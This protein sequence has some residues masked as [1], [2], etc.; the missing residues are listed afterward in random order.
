MK[1][2]KITWDYQYLKKQG[3]EYYNKKKYKEA[4]HYFKLAITALGE[5][6]A[7]I[8]FP[9]LH[10]YLY[11]STLL[12]DAPEIDILIKKKHYEEA[13]KKLETLSKYFLA[14]WIF[15]KLNECKE[16]ISREFK[17][18]NKDFKIIHPAVEGIRVVEKDL[19]FNLI[20]SEGKLL[21]K[22]WYDFVSPHINNGCR[23]VCDGREKWGYLDQEGEVKIPLV[24]QTVTTFNEEG[25][26]SVEKDDKFGV[27]DTQGKIIVPF[28]Y[29]Y[30]A[31]FDEGLAPFLVG[32]VWGFIDM[33][34]KVV[35]PPQYEETDSFSDGIC[36]VKKNGKW[37]AIN[38]ENTI[39][40]PFLFDNIFP[41]VNSVGAVEVVGEYYHISKRGI[42]LG[43]ANYY[44]KEIFEP[45]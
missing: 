13:I 24:Y 4:I 45:K 8:E 23:C 6:E 11:R 9:E 16:H 43:D 2:V 14:P 30:L 12:R 3:I 21:L 17:N 44:F 18:E 32:K 35:I 7:T 27:I 37:G 39:V 25:F 5:K 10:K 31:G 22:K 34:T 38:K 19:M 15:R 41:F 40:V 36:G 20:N 26:A 28:Q 1:D 42:L 29:E 33:T